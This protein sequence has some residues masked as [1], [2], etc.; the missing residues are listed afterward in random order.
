MLVSMSEHEAFG[1]TVSE[2]LAAGARAVV[3]D[4]PAH[5]ELAE[6]TPPGR[7]TLVPFEGGS[8]RLAEALLRATE[9]DAR[10]QSFDVPSWDD[11]ARA[12]LELYEEVVASI[13]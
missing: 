13:S 4:I 5:R 1:L 6:R 9:G 10:P 2:A 7:V 11:V 3:S 8:E 12:T